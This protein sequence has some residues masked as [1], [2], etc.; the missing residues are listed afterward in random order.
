MGLLANWKCHKVV[1]AG[2]IISIGPM[3]D[4]GTGYAVEV[5]DGEGGHNVMNIAALIFA[6]GK[7]VEGDYLV[8]YGKPDNYIS[9]SPRKVFEDG[10]TRIQAEVS[11]VV[12]S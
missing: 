4:G 7:P 2:K 11:D 1:Q 5:E 3:A 12:R 8:F 9:W 6:R 10:Y